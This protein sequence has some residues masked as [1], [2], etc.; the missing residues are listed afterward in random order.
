MSILLK[1][2]LLFWFSTPQ[3]T[4]LENEK[5]MKQNNEHSQSMY[6]FGLDKC[7]FFFNDIS[8]HSLLILHFAL[9]SMDTDI[10]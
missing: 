5:D 7:V 4:I 2:S 10:L 3:K 6:E 9:I 1:V 8:I